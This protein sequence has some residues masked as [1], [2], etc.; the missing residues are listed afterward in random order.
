MALSVPYA[1]VCCVS[2]RQRL[3]LALDGDDEI[4]FDH[5]GNHVGAL[6]AVVDSIDNHSS[7]GEVSR[8]SEPLQEVGQ[9]SNL[10]C[11]IGV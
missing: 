6:T 11:V 4:S 9:F 2:G 3:L 7:S 1:R 10:N 8:L 5:R